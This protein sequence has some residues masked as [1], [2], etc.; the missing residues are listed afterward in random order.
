MDVRRRVTARDRP[1]RLEKRA[2]E[3]RALVEGALRIAFRRAAR[4]RPIVRTL[5]ASATV[6]DSVSDGFKST[7]I[8]FVAPSFANGLHQSWG[9]H[10]LAKLSEAKLATGIAI[11]LRDGMAVSGVR[12][13]AL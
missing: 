9:W 11:G 7:A 3:Y 5:L 4:S 13:R 6:H 1:D 8:T 2:A 12:K 10:K